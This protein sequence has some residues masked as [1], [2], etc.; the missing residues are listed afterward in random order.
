MGNENIISEEIS[1][2]VYFAR[3]VTFQR[4]QRFGDWI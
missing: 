3:R 2:F 1:D 4:A